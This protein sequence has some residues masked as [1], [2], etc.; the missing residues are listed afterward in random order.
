MPGKVVRS[1]AED[2]WYIDLQLGLAHGNRNWD[3]WLSSGYAGGG[4]YFYGAFFTELFNTAAQW[5]SRYWWM[6]FGTGGTWDILLIHT[7]GNDVG[8][9]SFRMDEAEFSRVDGFSSSDVNNNRTQIATGLKIGPGRHKFTIVM[10]DA[11]A[12][13]TG[14]KYYS[15]AQ[16]IL[17][18]RTA[19]LTTPTFGHP[20]G[21]L[22]YASRAITLM[23]WA[24]SGNTNWD[25][26]AAAIGTFST[27]GMLD[28]YELFSTGAQNAA[29]YW[30]LDIPAGQW[31]LELSYSTSSTWGII[32]IQVDGI[33]QQTVDGYT[34]SLVFGNLATVRL[35]IPFT[36]THRLQ[37]L[38]A[39]KNASSGGFVGD[40]SGLQLR[41]VSAMRG[42][43]QTFSPRIVPLTTF[44]SHGNTNWNTDFL[45]LTYV[46]TGDIES[47][48]TVNNARWWYLGLGNGT[49]TLDVLHTTGPNRGIY[50]VQIDDVQVGTFDGYSSGQVKNVRSSVSGISIANPGKHK[51]SFVMATKNAS[52]SQFFGTV[53][54]MQMRR[55]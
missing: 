27:Q 13:A 26:I 33:T 32:S 24:A 41:Q 5:S 3:W 29:R 52:S 6:D 37:L 38:M 9:Y 15:G 46:Y 47:N 14:L 31:D 42:T 39:T 45:D 51:L 54:A 28:S 40:V 12:G 25:S 19:G 4:G 34:A 53:T 11:N 7:T 8:I 44:W 16:G 10:A 22:G 2:P 18:R 23:P 1:Y 49:W 35:S 36:G 55:T 30:D 48:G 50:S 21:T 20:V 43:I 17:F